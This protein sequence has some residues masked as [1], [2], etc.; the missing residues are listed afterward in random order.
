MTPS[1]A[2]RDAENFSNGWGLS[3]NHGTPHTEGYTSLLWTLI[4]AIPH[5]TGIN[6]VLISKLAGILLT[7][8]TVIV[9]GT[10]VYSAAGDVPHASG[11]LGAVFAPVLFLSFP[12][13]AVHSILGMET[14]PARFPLLPC[15]GLVFPT[16][17]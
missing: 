11:L 13:C 2:L 6:A 8:G 14:A 3:F 16:P 5:A 15:S 1:S 9:L 10:V 7:L 17:R 12:F 4:M